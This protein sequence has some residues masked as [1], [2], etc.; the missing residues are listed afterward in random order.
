LGHPADPP[1]DEV[2]RHSGEESVSAVS[3]KSP[4]PSA[5][6]ERFLA[7]RRERMAAVGAL[8]LRDALWPPERAMRVGASPANRLSALTLVPEAAATALDAS[9]WD[10][11]G[12]AAVAP[13]R[14][15]GRRPDDLGLR[16]VQD[17]TETGST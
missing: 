16:R 7:R 4:S 6:D 15:E 12:G 11:D 5:F 1:P 8:R 9:Q 13:D 14:T 10:D 2:A 3:A 17:T